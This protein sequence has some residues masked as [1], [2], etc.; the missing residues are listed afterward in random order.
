MRRYG[1]F[2]VTNLLLTDDF[3]YENTRRL[4]GKLIQGGFVFY[5]R[6]QKIKFP[7]AFNSSCL[8]VIAFDKSD[9]SDNTN[10]IYGTGSYTTTDFFCLAERIDGTYPDDCNCQY[11]AIGV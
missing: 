9:S 3:S 6:N 1:V 4:A 2:H 8:S 11:I 10:W 7:V 5:R